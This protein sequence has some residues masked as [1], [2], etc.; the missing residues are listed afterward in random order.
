[1]NIY[2]YNSPTWPCTYTHSH[3][4]MFIQ[5]RL[6]TQYTHTYVHFWNLYRSDLLVFY[7]CIMLKMNFPNQNML[8]RMHTPKF[9]SMDSQRKKR[10]RKKRASPYQLKRF[11]ILWVYFLNFLCLKYLFFDKGRD[12]FSMM[13]NP[14]SNDRKC[15]RFLKY[16][17]P[18][19][20][21]Q[22]L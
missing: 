21:P 17:G 11:T 10:G 5:I 9:S 4:C 3:T 13:I 19:L 22:S 15:V 8:K 16:L 18:R 1:M 20:Q 12:Y 14:L 6:Y 2:T 7:N